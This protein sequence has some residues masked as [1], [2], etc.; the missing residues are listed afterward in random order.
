LDCCHA[1]FRPRPG[2]GL[3]VQGGTEEVLAA[4]TWEGKTTGLG[5][6]SFTRAIVDELK[7]NDRAPTTTCLLHTKLLD[8]K[9]YHN[10]NVTV[11]IYEVLHGS[12]AAPIIRIAAQDDADVSRELSEIRRPRTMMEMETRF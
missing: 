12:D 2:P 8:H 11:P 4:A 7:L 1:S 3:I 9:Q 5:P 6:R 10:H